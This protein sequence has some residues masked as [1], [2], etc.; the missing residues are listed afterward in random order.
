MVMKILYAT[1]DEKI[2]IDEHGNLN[3]QPAG[4]VQAE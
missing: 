3:I 2:E 1:E 4:E